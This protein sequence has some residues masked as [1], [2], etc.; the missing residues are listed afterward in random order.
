M[1]AKKQ[2]Q[3]TRARKHTQIE[4][5]SIAGAKARLAPLGLIMYAQHYLHAAKT[6]QP[7][8]GG[9]ELYHPAR[10]FLVC[11]SL[12]LA[13]K[14][15][16]SLRGRSLDELSG[17]AFAHDLDKLLVEADKQDLAAL[18]ELSEDQ[19]WQIGRASIYYA[20]KVY[21]YPSVLEAMMAYPSQANMEILLDAAETLITPLR[22]PCLHA[23]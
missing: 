12:E 8:P 19:R 18:V 6:A 22:E 11:R 5:I 10:L 20:E 7:W 9:G 4:S 15:F 14:A 3:R 13:L 2:K 16:L 1:M 23:E 21:E 17:G